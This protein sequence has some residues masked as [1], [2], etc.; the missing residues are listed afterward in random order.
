MHLNLEK[1]PANPKIIVGFPGFGLVGTIATKFLLEHLETD[2][3][4]S[5]ESDRLLPLAAIHKSKL[6]GP[7]DIFYNKKYNLVIVQSLSEINGFEWKVSEILQELAETLKAKEVIILEGVPTTKKKKD[8][9]LYYFSNKNKEFSK[10]GIEPIQE[11]VMMGGTATLLLRCKKTPVSA[12]LA[13]GHSQMPDSEAAARIIEALDKSL[14]MNLN[15]KPLIQA[16]KKFETMLK[17]LMDKMKV[18]QGLQGQQQPPPY[19]TE[20]ADLDYLG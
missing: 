14:G 12:L 18:Q 15:P 10:I 13:E 9:G 11:A 7:L 3:I 8:Y 5:V 6:I 2:H 4:G 17:G 16:A 20:K 19:K 1:R